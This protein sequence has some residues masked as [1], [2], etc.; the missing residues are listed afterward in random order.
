LVET[1]FPIHLLD[2]FNRSILGRGPRLG[3]HQ[4]GFGV[5]TSSK[6]MEERSFGM[7]S[8]HMGG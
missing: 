3:R 2:D 8:K 4:Q 5:S 6:W 1:F 7:V